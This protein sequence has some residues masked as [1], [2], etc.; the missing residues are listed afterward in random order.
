MNWFFIALC[1]QFLWSLV[2]ISDQYLVAKYSIGERTSGGLIF[3]STIIGFF[4][5]IL[6][7]IFTKGIFGIPIIDKLLLISTGA[8]TITWFILYLYTLEIED[9]SAVVPWFLTIPIFGYGLGYIFLGEILSSKQLIGSL[10]ILLGVFLISIDFS[11]QK[12]K[13]KRKPALYMLIVCFLIAVSGVIFKYVTIGNNFWISSFWQ[14]VGLSLFG[15]MVFIFVSKYRNE[16]ILMSKNGGIKIFTLNTISEILTIIGNLLVNYALLLAPVVM[17][18]LVGS[19]Q[20]VILLFMTLL[21]TKFFPNIVKE[22]LDK[23]VLLP[24]LIAVLIM[25]VGSILLFI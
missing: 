6:I 22:N 11:G 21:A 16:F 10:I 8:I 23:Q 15:L 18:Y 14:Y 19:F 7:G 24:K 13:L 9:I 20:P 25:I 1:A 3:F 5:T 2:N 4:V 17:I 12:K